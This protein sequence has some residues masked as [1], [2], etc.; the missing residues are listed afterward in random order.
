MI[1]TYM[2]LSCGP[3]SSSSPWVMVTGASDSL[4]SSSLSLSRV[5][6]L[7]PESGS[8][9][10]YF[11]YGFS[12]VLKRRSELTEG[13]W[14]GRLPSPSP[15]SGSSE[16]KRRSGIRFLTFGSKMKGFRF[17]FMT[18]AVTSSSRLSNSTRVFLTP[19]SRGFTCWYT[20]LLPAIRSGAGYFGGEKTRVALLLL[21]RSLSILACAT[22]TRWLM[23][24]SWSRPS[25][26]RQLRRLKMSAATASRY[27]RP[28]TSCRYD[29]SLRRAGK[30]TGTLYT[31]HAIVAANG[32]SKDCAAEAIVT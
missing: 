3:L 16:E 30:T 23:A 1:G 14:R 6:V 18:S 26:T 32:E 10:T 22:L 21:L 27:S 28:S 13:R 5:F 7:A 15:C 12:E 31:W 9:T 11:L 4:S 2:T 24:A 29:S 20:V 8:S 17:A 19:C 25:T